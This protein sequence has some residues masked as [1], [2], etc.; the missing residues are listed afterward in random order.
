MLISDNRSDTPYCSPSELLALAPLF[1]PPNQ[2]AKFQVTP[3]SSTP[4]TV[5]PPCFVNCIPQ[6]GYSQCGTLLSALVTNASDFCRV[7]WTQV[8]DLKTY[9]LWLRGYVIFFCYTW[10]SRIEHTALRSR[11]RRIHYRHNEDTS[12]VYLLDFTHPWTVMFGKF[13]GDRHLCRL[14]FFKSALFRV[15]VSFRFQFYKR[16]RRFH[17][18]FTLPCLFG[19]SSVKYSWCDDLCSLQVTPGL[20]VSSMWRP[21][22]G[23]LQCQVS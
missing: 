6:M 14:L 1:F 8:V 7:H 2:S 18:P 22:A 21:R 10:D 19:C 11:S 23:G 13:Q 12:S 3:G 15:F 20:P 16:A 9:N 5:P 4:S 17:R